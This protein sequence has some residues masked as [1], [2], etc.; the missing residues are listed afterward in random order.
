MS[1]AG[2]D[3]VSELGLDDVRFRRGLARLVASPVATDAELDAVEQAA[4][5]SG[6]RK[7]GLDEV[8]GCRLAIRAGHADDRELVSGVSVTGGREFGQ[9][10]AGI[11][12][13]DQR[14]IRV[15]VGEELPNIPLIFLDD[16]YRGSIGQRRFEIAM[17]I[18]REARQRYE[19]VTRCNRP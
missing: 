9:R 11:S 16:E 7:H 13:D 5:V 2:G 19:R 15:S 6:G 1:V 4:G 12:D 18:D 8:R 10:G 17:T 3:H 14:Q